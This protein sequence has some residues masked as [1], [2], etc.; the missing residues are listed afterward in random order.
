MCIGTAVKALINAISKEAPVGWNTY[1][2][3]SYT[4]KPNDINNAKGEGG[5][6]KNIEVD[7][8]RHKKALSIFQSLDSLLQKKIEIEYLKSCDPMSR[9]Y[10][11]K[12]GIESILV[13]ETGMS[14]FLLRNYNS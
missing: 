14:E 11:D 9:M 7:A 13:F 12:F 1:P 5:E 6:P 8:G 10:Y 3:F 2:K 4:A